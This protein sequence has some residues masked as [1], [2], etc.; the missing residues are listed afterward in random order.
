MDGKPAMVRGSAESAF[1]KDLS[2]LLSTA[3][4]VIA[5]VSLAA[6]AGRS[7]EV[8]RLDAERCACLPLAICGL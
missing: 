2:N 7:V 8:A 4:T 3:A 6:V 1:A 5:T